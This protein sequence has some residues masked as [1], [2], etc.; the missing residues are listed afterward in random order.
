MSKEHRT[1]RESLSLAGKMAARISALLCALLML[2]VLPLLFHNAFFDINR[3]KVQAVRTLVPPLSAVFVLGRLLEGRPSGKGR[4]QA[5]HGVTLCVLLLVLA[6]VL[7]CARTGFEESTLTG[8]NGRY[9]G[10][11]FMLCCA[12][13]YGVIAYGLRDM[14]PLLPLIMLCSA[15]C[16]GLGVLNAMGI[17]PLGFYTYIRPGQE[18][19]FLSTIGN[20]DF[21]GTYLVMLLPICAAQAIF[22]PRAGMRRYGAVCSVAVMLGAAVSRTDCAYAGTHLV[23]FL[24]LMLC[25]A[26]L[27]GMARALSVW[28]AASAC[29]YAARR[30]LYRGLYR[31]TFSGLPKLLTDYYRTLILA[32]LLA[33][34]ALVCALLARRGVRA[35][36]RR[37]LAAAG[38]AL[39]LLA[40]L[41]LAGMTI[42]FNCIDTITPLGQ[43][44]S[45][46]RFG[47]GWGSHRGFVY[48][49]SLRA[50]GDYGWADR[51]F[52]RGMEQTLSILEPYCEESV[53]AVTGI[54]ND[55]HCQPLQLLLTCGILGAASFL[56]LYGASLLVAAKRLGGSALMTGLFAALAVYGMVMLLNVTQPILIG[57]YFSLIALTVAC[58]RQQEIPENRQKND[59]EG[60]LRES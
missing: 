38:L 51:L 17:D 45:V 36:G 11:L 27:D 52:G 4:G 60:A 55:A 35:P 48:A 9:C 42:Y 39:L 19:F 28:S 31:P 1:A 20:Y 21:F 49:R 53:I 22:S 40:A 10:L 5:G 44:E 29:Q 2:C 46:L 41:A 26:R 25:G 13:A 14:R 37:R 33:A 32:V 6:C 18:E 50:F 34:A 56:A 7:A 16:A 24:L 43:L 15:L 8:S 54:F 58:A 3:F 59:K 23:C 57:T 30:L 12:A 47:D